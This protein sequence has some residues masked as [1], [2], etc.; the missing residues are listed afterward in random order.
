MI[1]KR[2]ER[3][4]L[5]FFALNQP[6]ISFSR[7]PENPIYP[8]IQ[9]LNFLSGGGMLL[10]LKRRIDYWSN[11]VGPKRALSKLS[12]GGSGFYNVHFGVK[13]AI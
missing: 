8:L 5:I 1:G 6:G 10:M 9:K 11:G 12:N 2:Q 3:Y 13:R 4:L 7:N